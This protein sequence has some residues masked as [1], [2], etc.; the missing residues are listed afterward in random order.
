MLLS[1]AFVMLTG[2]CDLEEDRVW[3]PIAPPS[4]SFPRMC[5]Q[6]Q[7]VVEQCLQWSES[8]G[9]TTLRGAS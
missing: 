6:D 4:F 5:T 7:E 8:L 2:D 9:E 1:C 3:G